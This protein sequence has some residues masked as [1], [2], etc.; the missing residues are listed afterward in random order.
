VEAGA[1]TKQGGLFESEIEIEIDIDI[2][3]FD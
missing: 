1:R 3:H 2:A